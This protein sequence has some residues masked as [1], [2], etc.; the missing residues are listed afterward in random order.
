MKAGDSRTETFNVTSA[1]GSAE[2]TITVVIHGAND[3]PV[4][5]NDSK[6]TNENT[7][8]NNR[9]PFAVDARHAS[10]D[11]GNL[12]H[13]VERYDQPHLLVLQP[14]KWF[15]R[16]R[17]CHWE[18]AWIC[19]TS[20]HGASIPEPP[21]LRFVALY[22]LASIARARLCSSPSSRLAITRLAL[23]RNGETTAYR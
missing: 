19:V 14:H 16:V 20:G 21:E 13:F 5:S 9:V 6:S 7:V 10:R 3:V 4:V 15:L 2:Q 1:D 23:L 8:L 11:S 18:C 22:P 12:C 17:R